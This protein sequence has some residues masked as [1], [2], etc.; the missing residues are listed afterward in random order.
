MSNQDCNN[1][2]CEVEY[3]W[4]LSIIDARPMI[5]IQYGIMRQGENSLQ[6]YI[7]QKGRK[8]FGDRGVKAVTKEVDQLHKP[9]CLQPI[10]IL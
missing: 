9:Y 1:F 5:Q 2:E 10:D 3:T 7:L 4:R 8:T 6:Q